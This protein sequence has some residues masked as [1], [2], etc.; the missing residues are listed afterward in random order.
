MTTSDAGNVLRFNPTI[1]QGVDTV[2]VQQTDEAKAKVTNAIQSGE[3]PAALSN[4]GEISEGDLSSLLTDISIPPEVQKDTGF[5][6]WVKSKFQTE[7]KAPAADAQKDKVYTSEQ[8]AEL[9]AQVDS[10]T[11]L[12]DEQFEEL[13]A[14]YMQLLG[15]QSPE[16]QTIGQ[17]QMYLC[18]HDCLDESGNF[19]LPD[20]FK[21][22]P[23]E[24]Q[25]Y[26]MKTYNSVCSEAQIQD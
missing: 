16:A 3:L 8:L 11:P 26:I 20:D 12:S 22:Q 18:S 23:Q 24:V 17:A 15:K 1:A 13:S 4:K 19:K 25:D 21:D 9:Q 10:G 2:G 7:T 14:Q 5:W 6:G